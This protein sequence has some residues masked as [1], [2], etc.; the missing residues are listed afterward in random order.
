MP[1]LHIL[2]TAQ[3]SRPVFGKRQTVRKRK[4]LL[5]SAYLYCFTATEAQQ[6]REYEASAVSLLPFRHDK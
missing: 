6:P 2:D 3:N 5:R 4:Y 1:T